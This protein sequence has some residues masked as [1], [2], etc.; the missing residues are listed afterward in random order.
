MSPWAGR[1]SQSVDCET[2]ESRDLLQLLEEAGPQVGDPSWEAGS[3]EQ[4]ESQASLKGRTALESD[5]VGQG[6]VGCRNLR[7]LGGW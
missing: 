2:V 5:Q 7:G 1:V 3:D 4:V 6:E